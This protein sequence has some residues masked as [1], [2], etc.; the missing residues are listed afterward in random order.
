MRLSQDKARHL[1]RM[2]WRERAKRFLPLILAAVVLFA[3]ATVFLVRQI[4]RADR[5]LEVATRTGVVTEH[6]IGMRKAAV[7]HVHL[8]DGRN[9][10]VFSTLR[11]AP[12]VG[13]HVVI[14]EARHASGKH[15]YD[16][17]RVAE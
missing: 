11:V 7:V 10:D 2:V 17:V 16:L 15:T 6:E 12:A 5:T 3:A 8:D 9:V 13:A 1:S 4:G 14:S